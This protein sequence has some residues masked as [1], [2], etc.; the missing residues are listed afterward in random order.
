[1]QACE[2]FRY[3]RQIRLIRR[4]NLKY[5]HIRIWICGYFRFTRQIRR[6]R[7]VIILTSN[8]MCGYAD[9]QVF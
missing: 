7:R 5:P 4:V 3:T 1:M 6:I 8:I 2:Y 9:M